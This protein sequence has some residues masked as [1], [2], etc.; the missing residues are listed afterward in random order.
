[1]AVQ[2]VGALQLWAPHARS[3]MLPLGHLLAILCSEP[4]MSS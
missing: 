2:T 4:S 3:F 1:M